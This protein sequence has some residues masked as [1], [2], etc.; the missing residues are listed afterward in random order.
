MSRS[1]RGRGRAPT[2]FTQRDYSIPEKQPNDANKKKLFGV[3]QTGDYEDIKKI[4][5]DKNVILKG[6]NED[7]DNIIHV[8]IKNEQSGLEEYQ[9]YDLVKQFIYHGVPVG[10][11]NNSNVTPLHLAAKYQYPSIVKLL[12]EYE[13]NPNALDSQD[14]TPVHYA[15]YGFIEECRRTKHLGSLVSDGGIDMKIKPNISS[16]NLI[17]TIIDLLGFTNN[18][19]NKIF[20]TFTK[21]M[22]NS[23]ENLPEIFPEEYKEEED[24]FL[25]E[26]G[27]VINKNISNE[28]KKDEI[29]NKIKFASDNLNRLAEK[30][31]KSALQE[32]TIK[33]K[34]KNGW[35][36]ID[37]ANATEFDKILVPNNKKIEAIDVTTNAQKKIIDDLIKINEDKIKD[38][39]DENTSFIDIRQDMFQR[40]YNILYHNLHMML[41]AP[42]MNNYD[43]DTSKPFIEWM[44]LANLILDDRDELFYFVEVDYVVDGGNYNNNIAVLDDN[45]I[46]QKINTMH[47]TRMIDQD[48]FMYAPPIDQMKPVVAVRLTDEKIKNNPKIR[49]ELLPLTHDMIYNNGMYYD[50]SGANVNDISQRFN[51]DVKNFLVKERDANDKRTKLERYN[52]ALDRIQNILNDQR[53][54]KNTGTS[55]RKD[56]ENASGAEIDHLTRLV[57]LTKKIVGDMGTNLGLYAEFINIA[58]FNKYTSLIMNEIGAINIDISNNIN[59]IALDQLMGDS[60]L[61]LDTVINNSMVT[62]GQIING[63]E[64]NLANLMNENIRDISIS[65]HLS[66]GIEKSVYWMNGTNR[67]ERDINSHNIYYYNG[68]TFAGGNLDDLFNNDTNNYYNPN[69][70]LGQVMVNESGRSKYA[71]R[72]LYYFSRFIFY[73]IQISKHCDIIRHNLDT[74]KK[75]LYADYYYAIYADLIP[76]MINSI[77]NVFQNII[78]LKSEAKKVITRSKEITDKYTKLIRNYKTHPY[79]WSLEQA[80]NHALAIKTMAEDVVKRSITLYDNLVGLQEMLNKIIEYINN[81]ASNKF[82]TKM[83]NETDPTIKVLDIFDKGLAM[84]KPFQRSIDD[85]GKEYFSVIIN[86]DNV[87]NEL[88]KIRKKLIETY[89]I[90]INVNYYVTYITEKAGSIDGY[91]YPAVHPD[92]FN[93]IELDKLRIEEDVINTETTIPTPPNNILLPRSGFLWK[94]DFILPVPDLPYGDRVLNELEQPVATKIGAVGFSTRADE[95]NRQ[96]SSSIIPAGQNITETYFNIIKTLLVQNIIGLFHNKNV[97]QGIPDIGSAI[98]DTTGGTQ[99]QNEKAKALIDSIDSVNNTIENELASYNIDEHK[100]ETMRNIIIAK[101][102]DKLL[103]RN[104]EHYIKKSSYNFLMKRAFKKYNNSYFTDI[105]PEQVILG[106]DH[107]FTLNLG[108]LVEDITVPLEEEDNSNNFEFWKLKYG[109]NLMENPDTAYEQYKIYNSNYVNTMNTVIQQCYKIRT[110]IIDILAK[111][112]GQVNGK[113]YSLSTPIFYALETLYPKLVK[114]LIDNG[115]FVFSKQLQNRVGLT[116]FEYNIQIYKNHSDFLYDRYN[117]DNTIKNKDNGIIEKFY[118][119]FYKSIV[120]SVRSK[121]E[122]KNNIIKYLDIVFPQLLIMYNNMFYLYMVNYINEW[123]H[124][125]NKRLL[126]VINK[127][128]NI[129]ISDIYDDPLYLL[130]GDLTQIVKNSS[131][132]VVLGERTENVKKHIKELE[133]RLEKRRNSMTSIQKDIDNY[134][135][136]PSKSAYIQTLTDKQGVINLQITDI[137]KKI[138]DLTNTISKLN[139]R[140]SVGTQ[141]VLD[142]LTKKKNQFEG[143]DKHIGVRSSSKMYDN[144]F[145]DVIS[146]SYNNRTDKQNVGHE[147]YMLYNELW[148]H[149]INNDQL[150][151]VSNIHILLVKTQRQILERI[152]GAQND[153][154]TLLEVQNDMQIINDVYK[155][156]FV[157]LIDHMFELKQEYN[158][159]NF[160]FKNVVDIIIHIVKHTIF[161]NYYL[162]II[163][164]FQEYFKNINPYETKKITPDPLSEHNVVNNADDRK[165]MIEDNKVIQ[166]Y[167]SSK[168]TYRKYID[169]A[170]QRFIQYEYEDNA[171]LHDYIMNDM[172]L[173]SVKL[174]LNA[175]E[176]DYDQH[177]NI[178]SL[179]SIFATIENII[180][181]NPVISIDSE[182]KL[183]KN[184]KTFI[185]PY[186]RELINDVVPKMKTVVN[187]YSRYIINDSRYIDITTIL[188]NKAEEEL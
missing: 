101:A 139:S 57:K 115:A 50:L 26:I 18:T 116:P 74:L 143:T 29:Y 35:S 63:I 32:L 103:I 157:P 71:G 1:T 49:H 160:V 123:G 68:I 31:L 77:L 95:T 134:K 73:M 34:T 128:L 133:K 27:A 172:P 111:K 9:K 83:I 20:R 93:T 173:I 8:I 106:E 15:V 39:I 19:G 144:L 122:Y 141:R 3:V 97:F 127:Y 12:L 132:L 182:S 46:I 175:Y 28:A 92:I 48:H 42:L 162:V 78:F 148:R 165:D 25:Q 121:P 183:I 82:M 174:L 75:H 178:E 41:N 181:N 142:K 40:I 99:Q 154:D 79:I 185:H 184:L 117:T 60:D 145:K 156:I 80:G 188:L 130:K 140:M 166:I 164:M 158:F 47:G 53:T 66:K 114:T 11:F 4:I 186:Y 70:L 135:N 118:Y 85:Y 125:K 163:R 151:N 146:N 109:V 153:K 120:D 155:E 94:H 159:E 112:N 36:P 131:D 90:N 76:N 84:L 102:V 187:N 33:P 98:I 69:A 10:Q 91:V 179:E 113:D 169:E 167:G 171:P 72:S 149:Y 87:T 16:E 168:S 126:Q 2:T 108:K 21:N 67:E 55:S 65:D 177:R 62:I 100:R 30:H 180:I 23:I 161:S 45:D 138:T 17:V 56:I 136:D 59:T 137:Q 37:T 38:L 5:S 51:D 110:E 43:K 61:N 14:M 124:D 44:D 7:G 52:N 107:G 88:N 89:A 129:N 105:S 64:R 6:T 86:N 13:A 176:S 150:N 152:K 104:L 58:D 119:P 96:R 170:T 54:I 147:E 22:M 81:Q 24:K